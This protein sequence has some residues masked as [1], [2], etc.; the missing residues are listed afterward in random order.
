MLWVTLAHEPV[1]EPDADAFT[2]PW[3]FLRSIGVRA[4]LDTVK[5]YLPLHGFRSTDTALH[6][7]G[8]LAG[9]MLQLLTL[10]TTA[11]DCLLHLLSEVAPPMDIVPGLFGAMRHLR[12][13]LQAPRA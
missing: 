7:Q 2:R 3:H 10:Q 11:T 9:Q 5:T 4:P 6:W 1:S 13:T 8:P 12:N